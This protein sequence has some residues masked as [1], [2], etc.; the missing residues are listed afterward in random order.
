MISLK[1]NICPWQLEESVVGQLGSIIHPGSCMSWTG[2]VSCF[3]AHFFLFFQFDDELLL[4]GRQPMKPSSFCFPAAVFSNRSTT[5]SFRSF[6][7]SRLNTRYSNLAVDDQE[8]RIRGYTVVTL[9]VPDYSTISDLIGRVSTR[10][11]VKGSC[12]SFAAAIRDRGEEISNIA[13]HLDSIQE[14]VGDDSRS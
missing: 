1:R 11:I 9:P 7:S 3:W 10:E 13:L 14:P 2:W 8:R 5:L 12:R 6:C 4:E